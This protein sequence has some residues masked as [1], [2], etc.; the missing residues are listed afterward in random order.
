MDAVVRTLDLLRR[1]GGA[2]ARLLS[3]PLIRRMPMTT[4]QLNR[5]CQPRPDCGTSTSRVSRH[6]C[7]TALPPHLPDPNIDV[8]VIHVL[9]GPAK[10]RPTSLYTRRCHKTISEVP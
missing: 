10:A 5:A 2:P 1:L 9:R 6:P 3:E 7:G 4:R 8:R